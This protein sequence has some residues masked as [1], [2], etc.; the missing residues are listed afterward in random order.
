MVEQQWNYYVWRIK[1]RI[2]IL[3]NYVNYRPVAR[4]LVQTRNVRN[5]SLHVEKLQQLFKT[6]SPNIGAKLSSV[7]RLLSIFNMINSSEEF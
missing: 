4:K 3:F 6:N 2:N 7:T 1:K 5:L